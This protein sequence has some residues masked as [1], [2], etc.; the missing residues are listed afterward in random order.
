[1]NKAKR[2][3]FGQ[4]IV[5]DPKICGGDLTFKGTRILVKDV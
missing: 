5:S 2:I 3:E 4:H 1:M